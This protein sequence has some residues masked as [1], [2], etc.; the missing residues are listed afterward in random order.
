[1]DDFE[2]NGDLPSHRGHF[3]NSVN[4]QDSFCNEAGRVD[5]FFDLM[6]RVCFPILS[7]ESVVVDNAARRSESV[8]G[9]SYEVLR[10]GWMVHY[11]STHALCKL[12]SDDLP[13]ISEVDV[14]L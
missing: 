6:S 14:D 2:V 10:C 9:H 8:T 11:H 13:C 1:M 12:F 4:P 7:C 3:T 5:P